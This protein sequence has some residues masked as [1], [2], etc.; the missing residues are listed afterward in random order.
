MKDLE[1]ASSMLK[2]ARDDY[3]AMTGMLD[4]TLFTDAIFGFHTQQAVEKS[5]KAWLSALGLSYHPPIHVIGRLLAQLESVTDV[6]P[7]WHWGTF[8]PFAVQYR[9]ET[10]DGDEL[11]LPRVVLIEQVSELLKK[12]AGQIQQ[13]ND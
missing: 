8:T 4:T 3:T 7:F 2:M 6:T 1:H 9:Y 13:T 12:V 10:V 5:L 11:P